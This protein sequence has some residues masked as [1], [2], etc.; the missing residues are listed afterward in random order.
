MCCTLLMLIFL[1]LLVNNEEVEAANKGIQSFDFH[2][3]FFL[4]IFL[5]RMGGTDYNCLQLKRTGTTARECK[6]LRFL[7]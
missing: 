4:L 3:I 7:L 2:N 5:L 1:I 6:G